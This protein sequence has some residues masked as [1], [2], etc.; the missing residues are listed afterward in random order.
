MERTAHRLNFSRFYKE[1]SAQV[2]F[3][4]DSGSFDEADVRVTRLWDFDM[5]YI[6]TPQ[7]TPH[8]LNADCIGDVTAL[9]TV[10]TY[11]LSTKPLQE[12]FLPEEETRRNNHSFILYVLAVSICISSGFILLLRL[13]RRMSET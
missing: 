11:E 7:D 6:H 1:R 2:V 13:R 8:T 12:V 3:G 10:V 9:I 5:E 4:S